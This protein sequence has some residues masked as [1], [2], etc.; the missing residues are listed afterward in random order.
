[1]K[2]KIFLVICGAFFF[3]SCD[4]IFLDVEGKEADLQGKWQMDSADTVYYNFQN[5]LFLYQIYRVKDRTSNV[6]GYY[7]LHG[8]TAIDLQ[9]L[10]TQ[11]GFP[12]D[13][14][15]WDT[16]PAS[17]GND[18]ICKLFNIKQLTSKKLILSSGGKDIS[19]HKF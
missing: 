14:L 19:F 5:N 17:D 13:Y 12:L 3:C 18:T 9:L 1:M 11:A 7:I 4:K 15:G 16:I 2:F 8:D 10:G 6:Y